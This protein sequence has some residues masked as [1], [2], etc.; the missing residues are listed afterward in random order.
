MS[1]FA[2]TD[3]KEIKKH[4]SD[5]VVR[6]LQRDPFAQFTGA[7]HQNCVIAVPESSKGAS[8]IQISIVSDL[9]G[10]G[11]KG[12]QDLDEGEDDLEFLQFPFKG[13]L[14]ANSHK[15]PVDKIMDKTTAGSW[16][17]EKKTSLVAWFT[18]RTV[19]EK[20]YTI[21]N[22]PTNLV[23]VKKDGT[24]GATTADLAEGD[25]FNT[26]VIDE[27]LDRA[28]NGWV[29]ANDV[30]HPSLESYFI[31]KSTEHGMEQVGEFYPIFV[32]PQ[33]YKAL[34]DD[35]RWQEAQK[36]QAYAGLSSA[37][38]GY[39]GVYRNAVIIKVPKTSVLKAGIIR[40]DSPDFNGVYSY[41]GFSEFKAG[42]DIVTELNFMMGAGALA[43]GFDEE[44][45]Y[46]EDDTADSGRKVKAW[47]D[48]FFGTKK[49]RFVGETTEEKA[50]LYHD[51]D[52]AVI[53][54]PSTI[55]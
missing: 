2:I 44:P 5:I 39:G 14:I 52:Y 33:S 17:R 30:E 7:T 32:G 4:G 26:F 55:K 23:I 22:D 12:N 48:Q 36:H 38:K 16:R 31:E 34:L 50:S 49:V 1:S 35:P 42:G 28:E 25:T 9:I 21:S 45:R 19:K 27:M 18:R 29:D 24:A 3:L 15:S 8:Q 11:V 40:S 51:K 20:F 54:A 37:V 13:D 10:A 53:V 43:L 41:T 6:M 46:A 47:S